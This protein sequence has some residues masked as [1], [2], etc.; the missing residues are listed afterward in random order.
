MRLRSV[1]EQVVTTGYLGPTVSFGAGGVFS[2]GHDLSPGQQRAGDPLQRYGEFRGAQPGPAAE[3]ARLAPGPPSRWPAAAASAPGRCRRPSWT[4]CSPPARR[5]SRAGSQSTTASPGDPGFG[6]AQETC[7]GS[8]FLTAAKCPAAGLVSRAFPAQH[9]ERRA[10]AL[11]RR[12]AGNHPLTL[13]VTKPQASKAQDAQ[14]SRTLPQDSL[15]DYAAMFMPGFSAIRHDSKRRRAAGPRRPRPARRAPRPGRH[16]PPDLTGG[17]EPAAPPA[18]PAPRNGTITTGAIRPLRGAGT[19][20][21]VNQ[22]RTGAGHRDL[23][24]TDSPA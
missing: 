23:T 15:G 7:P 5:R 10:R 13:P 11:A 24:R 20:G 9:R 22:H 4:R 1:G 2:A 17:P 18:A 16:P 14:G 19:A 8:R 3:G 12:V 21:P 6:T